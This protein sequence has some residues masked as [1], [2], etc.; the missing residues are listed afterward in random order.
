MNVEGFQW[1]VLL[2]IFSAIGLACNMLLVHVIAKDLPPI[3]NLHQ[4]NLGYVLASGTLC[5]FTPHRVAMEEVTW[6]LVLIMMGIVLTGF[7]TQFFIIKAN[8]LAK[9]S[10]VMPF[11]YVSVA[12]GFLADVILFGTQFT[13]LAIFGMIM[14][15]AGLL[16]NILSEKLEVKK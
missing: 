12:I 2:M 11:G 7:F 16:G 5:S 1:Y 14:T 15:S 6:V 3:V 9:P 10:L 13:G 4:S 8:S